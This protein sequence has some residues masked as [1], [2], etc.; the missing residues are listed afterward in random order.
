MARNAAIVDDDRTGGRPQR[1]DRG[2]RG[3]ARHGPHVVGAGRRPA[4]RRRGRA[5]G[6]PARVAA[7]VPVELVLNGMAQAG[8]G[9]SGRIGVTRSD[10]AA[11]RP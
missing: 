2:M 5:H 1:L 7:V 10:Y 9:A 4:V 11:G 6:Q 3:A 8:G